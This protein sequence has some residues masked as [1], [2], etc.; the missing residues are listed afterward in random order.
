MMNKCSNCR[1]PIGTIRC[2]ALEKVLE[3][4]RVPCRNVSYGC[5]ATSSY[6]KKLDHEKACECAPCSCPYTNCDYV[7]MS[8]FLYFHFAQAHSQSSRQFSFDSAI[9][10]SMGPNQ[11]QVFLQ[12]RNHNTLFI[13]NRTIKSLGDLVR[14]ICA[15]PASTEGSFLYDLTAVIDGDTS[16]KMKTSVECIPKLTA[17]ARSRKCLLVPRD[18]TELRGQLRLE[19]IL[20]RNPAFAG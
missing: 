8:K 11:M 20:R 13:L 5:K 14:V 12:E 2:R 18:L 7:G 15:A 1:C 3:S 6:N 19:L 9:S 10:I 16:I 17:R 4:V